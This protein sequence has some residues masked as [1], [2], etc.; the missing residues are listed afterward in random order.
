MSIIFHESTKVFH[1]HNDV[2][3]YIMMVLP[4]G[5]MGHLY[6]G[7]KIHDR[8]DFGDLLETAPRPMCSCPFEGNKA[9]SLEGIKQELPSYGT[10]D[11][12]SPAVEVIQENGSRISDFQYHS[13]HIEA[14]KPK[15][16]GLPATY[17]ESKKEA[18]TLVLNLFDSVTG[19]WAEL[20][21]T[22][23]ADG[24]IVARV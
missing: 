9:F 21:Y 11:Y 17:V 3:S 15:L 13:H 10:G 23:F 2:I 1:L 16:P 7:K 22:I 12:R 5:Q 18:E 6:F 4:N 14:G 24:G 8:E 20:F 19:I